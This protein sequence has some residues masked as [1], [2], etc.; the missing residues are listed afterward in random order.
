MNN[1]YKRSEVK[2]LFLSLVGTTEFLPSLR[3]LPTT[4]SPA[5]LEKRG[6]A[7]YPAKDE[8]SILYGWPSGQQD[9]GAGPDMVSGA[10][11]CR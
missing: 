6:G 8:H 11:I 3:S 4:P 1:F 7:G 2:I 10:L 9:H 5:D